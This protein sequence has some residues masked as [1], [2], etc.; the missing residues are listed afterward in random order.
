MFLDGTPQSYVDLDDPTNLVF[1]YV[2][3]IGHVADLVR[4][5]GDP[6]TAVHLGG[7]GFTLPR[8]I[9]ATR[10]GSRQQVIESDRALIDAVRAA[11]PLPKREQIKVRCADAAEAGALLPG[12][13]HGNVDLLILDVFAGARTPGALTTGEFFTSLVPLLAP[14]AAVALNIGDGPPLA[15][16]RS[17]TATVADVFGDVVVAAEPAIL[18]GR[19]FGN[20]VLVAGT[21]PDGLP[22][23][24]A[25]DPFPGTLLDGAEIAR[26]IGGAK[27]ITRDNAQDS[28]PPPRGVFG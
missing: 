2:R 25:G 21:V 12:G 26:F 10:P 20:L 8:Y 5:V 14:G 23:R 19:R 9:A 22:R 24:L 3:R 17:V 16:A 13:L 1:E 6:I 4:P 7:G 11:M 15:F 28:P 27:P 18:K